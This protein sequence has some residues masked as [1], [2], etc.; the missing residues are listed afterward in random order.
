MNKSPYLTKLNKVKKKIL[1]L[2]PDPDPLP[3]VSVSSVDHVLPLHIS[4]KS[5]V[6][7]IDCVLSF[8]KET[9][10]QGNNSFTALI[11]GL[12][13]AEHLHSLVYGSGFLQQWRW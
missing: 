1:D 8:T 10:T 11:C 3:N 5:I 7:I 9:T 6:Y 4:W 12:M 13:N 2:P